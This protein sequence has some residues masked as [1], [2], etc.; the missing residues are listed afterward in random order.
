MSP[1]PARPPR[2]WPIGIAVESS[3]PVDEVDQV[4]AIHRGGL[5]SSATSVRTWTAGTGPSTTSSIPARGLRRALL[6]PGLGHRG[7]LRG[8]QRVT[9]AAIVWGERA[10]DELPRFGQA[11]RLVRHDGQVFFV[12]GWP[13]GGGGM[14]STASGTPRGPAASWR[15]SC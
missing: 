8:G 9:T 2:G 6:G 5:A 1:W 12:N 13:E 7:Q 10:L 4:V 14:S 3:T 15:W 11:V